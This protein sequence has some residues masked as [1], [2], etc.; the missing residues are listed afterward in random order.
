MFAELV[1]YKKIHGDCNVLA[2]SGDLGQW[3]SKQRTYRKTE[4]R[5]ISQ[6]QIALLDSLDFCWELSL[7]NGIKSSKN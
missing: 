1:A 5:H 7:L 2:E 4:R 3:C 6:N